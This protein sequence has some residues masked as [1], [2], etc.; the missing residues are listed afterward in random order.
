MNQQ[1][2]SRL[3]KIKRD[4]KGNLRK[5]AT[6]CNVSPSTVSRVLDGK[7]INY[8]LLDQFIQFRDEIISN[9]EAKLKSILDK[10]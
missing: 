10:V 2:K 6:H 1:D 8:D 3:K 9:Q 7:I 4:L 5:C